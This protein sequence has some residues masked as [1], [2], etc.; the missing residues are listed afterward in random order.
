MVNPG[1]DVVARTAIGRLAFT[2][3]YR[4]QQ[5]DVIMFV[6]EKILTEGKFEWS[7]LGNCLPCSLSIRKQN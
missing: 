1:Q 5:K 6:K 4:H 3:T 2:V 7:F